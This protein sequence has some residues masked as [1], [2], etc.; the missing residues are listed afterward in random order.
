VI[1]TGIGLEK[2]VS[3][4]FYSVQASALGRWERIPVLHWSYCTLELK[5]VFRHSYHKTQ[6]LD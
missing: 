2:S 3:L 1:V 6:L 5:V 4:L